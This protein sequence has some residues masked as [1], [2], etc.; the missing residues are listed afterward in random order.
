MILTITPNSAL[1]VTYHLDHLRLGRSLRVSAV[2]Q[3]AGGKGVNVARVLHGLGEQTLSTGL[4]GGSTGQAVRAG[5]DE[6]GLPHDFVEI[7]GETRRTVT[8]VDSD[9]E[10]T[11]LL[12][13]GPVITAAEWT[14]FL[15][16]LRRLAPRASVLVV[17]GSLPQGVSPDSAATLVTIG[18]EAGIPVVLDTSGPAL[19]AA[20]AAK[21]TLVK[22]NL[23][24]LCAITPHLAFHDADEDEDEVRTRA[25]A[26]R[27]LGA[28]AVVCSL[29][30]DGMIA[31]ID[32]H[33]WHARLNPG[34]QV[35]GNPTGAGDAAV[36][37]LAVA[38][39]DR[40]PWSE[41]LRNAVALSAAAV[42]SP[43]A[44]AADPQIFHDLLPA[45]NIRPIG[46][47]AGQEMDAS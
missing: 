19:A 22:P 5:L 44:G 46:L 39:R 12:E 11:V 15:E 43:I 34:V 37:A 14:S 40:Q 35:S 7:A 36:A 26:V 2:Q 8:V 31:V 4:V 42:A 29:G 28:S 41:G 38:L 1:D 25:E 3:R 18:R 32:R 45:V 21:P 24:E 27:A 9:G 17:S 23:D 47:A 20:L 33:A 13:P 30:Q 10:A 16:H 6:V